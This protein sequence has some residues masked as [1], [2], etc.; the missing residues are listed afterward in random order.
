M[1]Y[2]LVV[3]C[4]LIAHISLAQ[5]LQQSIEKA[6]TRFEQDEQLRYG[7]SSLTVFNAE[8]GELVFSRNGNMGLASA[9]TLKTVTA[10]TALSILGKDF[11][12]ETTLGY[13]GRIK[14]GV[15]AGDLIL[16]GGG[17]PTLGSSRY[18]ETNKH[19]LLKKWV[20][21]IRQAGI[22][23]VHGRV[24]VDDHL[25]GTQ[26]L[27]DGWIWQDMGNYFGA[28]SAAISWNENQCELT[29]KP[30][31]QVGDP[32]KMVRSEPSIPYLKIVNEVK[33]GEAGSGDH[34]Y[35]Y[36]GPY[37]NVI[38]LRGTYA[39]DLKKIISISIP[40]PAF[41]VAFRLQ[42]TLKQLAI[43]IDQPPSTSRRLSIDSI[44]LSSSRRM[45]DAEINFKTLS[46]H[47]SP[48]LT[49]VIEAFN[50]KSINLYGEVL[51]KTL[52]WKEGKPSTTDEGVKIVKMF[53]ANKLG[54]DINTMNIIDGSGLSPATRITTQSMGSILCSARKEMWFDAFYKS[55]PIN[56]GM[57][58]KSG[59]INDVLAYAGYQTTSNGVPLAFSFIINNYNGSTSKIKKKM[60]VVLDILKK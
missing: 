6:Y 14:K 1:K 27:P 33:T 32:V 24:L 35:A 31:I 56:N 8:T 22:K 34:V 15:L 44:S 16:R 11:T 50:Q 36:S 3:T 13:L 58:M 46:I 25:F 53:W 9:S 51:L 38:Y 17:D 55:I 18:T 54:I 43:Q 19:V 52:A 42:D 29:L 37:S 4:L 26:T 45:Q 47:Q 48:P 5:M 21:A 23:Q 2:F 57:K 12:W 20:S 40:D 59:S 41:E 10:A 28:G 49:Q 7:I 60:F 30:A 39:I